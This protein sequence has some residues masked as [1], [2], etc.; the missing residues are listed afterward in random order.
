MFDFSSNARDIV[1][2]KTIQDVWEDVRDARYY[3]L[4]GIVAGI[5]LAVL[6]IAISVPH[7]RAQMIV[8]PA[9]TVVGEEL[10]SLMANDNL[11]AL[12]YLVNRV[13]GGT[14]TGDFTRFENTYA[15]PSVAKILLDDPIVVRGLK[16][17]RATRW[18]GPPPDFDA[19]R[20]SAY[21]QE[22]VRIENLGATSF[23]RLVYF[24]QNADFAEYFLTQIHQVTDALIRQNI[25]Q[26][27]AKR[28]NYLQDA[29]ENSYNP[30]HR[31]S[32]TTLLMEQE[33]LRMLVSLEQSYAAA[34]IE[35]AASSYKPQWPDKVLAVLV[36]VMLGAGLGFA[37]HS[38]RHG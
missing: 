34:V 29:M 13:G 21:V 28:I 23:R 18:S 12:R 4:G 26:E 33:R 10:S 20:L 22:R 1:A 5:V 35:P 17:D 24:H 9:N 37:V 14:G 19:A 31:R 15:G 27:A 3:I 2:V 16:A 11:F 30:E 36:F 8:A 38:V 7:F 25:S 6:F 32:L